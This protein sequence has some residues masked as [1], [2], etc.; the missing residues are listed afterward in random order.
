M[1]INDGGTTLNRI[2]NYMK[3]LFALSCIVLLTL[4]VSCDS[5]D[6]IN[7]S[8]NL[9]TESRDLQ[10][11]SKISSEGIFEVKVY[12]GPEQ[13]V[14]IR[15][16]DNVMDQVRTRVVNNE[17]QLYLKEGFSYRGI[18]LEATITATRLNGLFNSGAGDMVITGVDE[19]GSFT[20]GNFGS[21]NIS[22]EGSAADLTIRNEGS[23]DIL[24]FDFH[25][26]NCSLNLEGSG[27]AE[28]H[29]T[30][31]LDVTIEGSGNVYYKG[32][33]TVNTRI[34]GSGSVVDAN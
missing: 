29:C 26:E 1:I 4:F 12:Q 2:K 28:V 32:N 27:S 34:S 19:E 25:V 21:G 6:T 14:E 10:S 13:S 31:S 11:F 5:D 20:I 9:I 3:R 7:G 24:A 22:V 8:G 23:G 30:E 17:L 15:A 33:P 18:T 16:D